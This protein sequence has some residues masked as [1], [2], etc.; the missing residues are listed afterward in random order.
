MGNQLKIS[1]IR[2]DHRLMMLWWSRGEVVIT[3]T[4]L[5]STK[6]EVS[7]SAGSNPARGVWICNAENF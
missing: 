4:E 5:H 2:K 6:S 7:F 3:T 1:E